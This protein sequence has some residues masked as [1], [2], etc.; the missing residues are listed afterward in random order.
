[1]AND[2]PSPTC[3]ITIS[4]MCCDVILKWLPKVHCLNL[5]FQVDGAV[6]RGVGNV[7]RQGLAG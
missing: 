4:V 6:L 5:W 1:M 7:W 2:V 3:H